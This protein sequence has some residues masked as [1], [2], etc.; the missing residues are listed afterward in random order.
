MPASSYLRHP[1]YQN[2][3]IYF[4]D[5]VVRRDSHFRT[6]ADLR[7]ASWAYNERESHSGYNVVRYHL[8]THGEESAYFGDVVE[9]GAHLTSLRM[10]LERQVDASAI[11]SVVLGLESQRR[12]ALRA[13][14]RVI[15]SLGP[16]PIP[17]LVVSRSLPP[18]IRNTLRESLLHM[19]EDTHGQTILAN[20]R[21][22]RFAC[23]EDRDYD[24]I[25]SMTRAAE[26]ATL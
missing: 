4:S 14:I 10:I 13:A 24:A 22:V 17:P 18:G 12:P 11:D 6:F 7:G 16:S 5:V 1:R 8:A 23:V 25:R 19:H 3:P 20:I 9:S 21:I 26:R 15:E 2:R